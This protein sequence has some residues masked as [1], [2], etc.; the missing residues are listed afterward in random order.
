MTSFVLYIG[1][2]LLGSLATIL[3]KCKDE[4]KLS[5]QNEILTSENKEIK[6]EL[7]KISDEVDNRSIKLTIKLLSTVVTELEKG[8]VK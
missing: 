1:A 3:A 6:K 8:M 4:N 2:F 7:A 5:Q